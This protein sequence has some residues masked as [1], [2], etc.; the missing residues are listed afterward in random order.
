M[1]RPAAQRARRDEAAAPP[2]WFAGLY[3]DLSFAKSKLLTAAWEAG[4]E[5]PPLAPSRPP[6]RGFEGHFLEASEL[7]GTLRTLMLRLAEA[8]L[9]DS[10]S[11]REAADRL[12]GHFVPAG[13]LRAA[14][15]DALPDVLRLE[16]DWLRSFAD[17]VAFALRDVPQLAAFA[18]P[19]S[20]LPEPEQA[21][22]ELV[23]QAGGAQTLTEVAEQA[24][25]TR[26]AIH[27]RLLAGKLFGLRL[28]AGRYS[29]PLLQ[30]LPGSSPLQP[31]PGLDR[32]IALFREAGADGAP[33]LAFLAQEPDDGAPRPAE[34]LA[35]GEL[36]AVLRLA[37]RHLGLDGAPPSPA[38]LAPG[39]GSG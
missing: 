14:S 39:E 5:L 20:V 25:V 12:A 10:P 13:Q 22:G 1:L 15:A 32:V 21:L 19:A 18:V 3:S 24:G 17:Q 31:L 30:F 4:V 34:A 38:S 9:R 29:L 11:A 26:Q 7:I 8:D 35:Q 6:L 36:A 37:A 2:D 28:R 33:L 27:Q 16:A 23:E